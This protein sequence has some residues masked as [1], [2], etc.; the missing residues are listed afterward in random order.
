M[1]GIVDVGGGMRG[2]YTAGIYDYL[3][4]Q[5]IAADYCI[6][7]SAGS[8]N[9]VT[10]LAKQKGRNLRFYTEYSLR[11]EY[12][13]MGQF[14][15]RGSYL[16]MDYI[17]GTLTNE[18]GE[19]PLD[20]DMFAASP[21]RYTAVC[22]DAETG[23]ACYF[24]RESL[25]RNDY[26]VIKASCS[27]P[28]VCKPYQVNG[29]AYFDGGIADPVPYQKAFQD[30]C[31][32]VI[33]LLTRPAAFRRQPEGHMRFMKRMLKRYPA[34]VPALAQ[35]YKRYNDAL[36]DLKALQEKGTVLLL[37]PDDITGM[38][39]LTKDPEI[40]KGLYDKGRKDA[41]AIPDFMV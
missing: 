4:D 13:G 7:V 19:D 12:M 15:R 9:M 21:T 22:T 27:I 31:S 33:V 8:A 36:D 3:I 34:M 11:R 26:A 20:Y 38:K 1:I 32:K 5:D 16:N 37:A 39:T 17:Y 2:A 35:R 41:E 25:P 18:D 6:G 24:G 30:G 23:A 29:R 14:L 40:V 10:Y 28:G